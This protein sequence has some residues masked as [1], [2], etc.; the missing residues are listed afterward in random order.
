MQVAA[1]RQPGQHAGAVVRAA[2]LAAGLTL[3]ELGQRC[4]YS[5]SQIS[6]YERGVQPLTDITLLH[7]FAAALAIPPQ[8]FGLAPLDGTRAGRHAD[9]GLKGR[10]AA[11]RGPNVSGGFQLEGGEDPVRRRELLARA[12]GVAGAAAL[13]LPGASRAQALSDPGVHLDDLLYGSA[14][15]EP[16]P[17]AALRTATTQARTCFQTARYERLMCALPRLIAT[18]TATRDTA[19][20]DERAVASTLLADAYIVAAN[21][22]IKLN[23]DPIA[24]T[25]ADRALQAAQAGNDPLTV[26]DGRRAVATVLRR[27]G[28]C[29]KA[30]ELLMRA[31][32]D[33]EPS[34]VAGPDQLSMYGTLLEVGRAGTGS[35]SPAPTTNGANPNPATALCWQPNAPPP[36]KSATGHPSTA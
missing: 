12:A 7:R 23:D 21:F 9:A 17:L 27:T 22:V 11:N 36:P 34:G 13:G 8:I 4:G 6:R 5:A 20:G 29:V 10:G 1:D 19:D 30:R 26:A 16:V 24:W 14:D 28:R 2:R 32:R 15:A 33:I 18:A 3:A 35:T 25:L 31:A